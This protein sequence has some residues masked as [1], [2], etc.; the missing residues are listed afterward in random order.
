M[1]GPPSRRCELHDDDLVQGVAEIDY[2]IWVRDD[3]RIRA[4]RGLF[5]NSFLR[6]AGGCFYIATQP[7]AQVRYCPQC[8]EAE[9]AW[10]PFRDTFD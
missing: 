9:A 10:R 6:V 2:G 7:T 1:T 3:E 5:P 8:R 4:Q